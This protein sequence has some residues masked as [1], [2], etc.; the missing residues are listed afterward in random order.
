LPV[1]VERP[2]V[3]ILV[4]GSGPGDRD[5]SVGANRPLRDLAVGLAS[6]GIAV[7][8]YEK[9]TKVYPEDF[10]AVKAPTVNDETIDDVD[11]AVDLL[12]SWTEVDAGRII[13]VGHSLGATVAPR[14]AARNAF[15]AASSCSCRLRARS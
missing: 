2:P 5:E 7:L 8:R 3:A 6:H 15:V 4:H 13:V 1:G 14:I 11:R 12:R 10:L 9:R